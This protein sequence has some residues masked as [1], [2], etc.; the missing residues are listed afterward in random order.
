MS[1]FKKVGRILKSFDGAEFKYLVHC[2]NI[3]ESLSN[4]LNTGITK[5][6]FCQRFGIK[7]QQYKN[8]TLGN[9]NYN[10]RH[11][12]IL[13]AWFMGIEIEKAKKRVPFKVVNDETK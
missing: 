3:R 7:P 12:A 4:L 6:D 2:I 13:N 10:I 8:F 11:M 1:D 5:Q 9:F